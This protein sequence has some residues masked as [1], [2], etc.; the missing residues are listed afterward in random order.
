MLAS[1]VPDDPLHST[2][3]WSF[4]GLGPGFRAAASQPVTGRPDDV[5]ITLAIN[6]RAR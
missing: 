1:V 6:H 3:I 2:V 4:S 5:R